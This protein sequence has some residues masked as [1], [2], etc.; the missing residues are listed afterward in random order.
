MYD[1]AYYSH[2]NPMEFDEA[3][4]ESVTVERIAMASLREFGKNSNGVHVN[5]QND[6]DYRKLSR[7]PTT[8]VVGMKGLL[9]TWHLSNIMLYYN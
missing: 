8:L 6:F 3:L 9:D 7:K 4:P 2:S 5:W 1:L